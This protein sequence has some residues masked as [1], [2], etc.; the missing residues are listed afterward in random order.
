MVVRRYDDEKNENKKKELP[1]WLSAANIYT[2]NK[3]FL[4][5]P[6]V[7]SQTNKKKEMTICRN[8]DQQKASSS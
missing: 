2:Q 8:C 6:A 4:S 7:V 1:V 5:R 3:F